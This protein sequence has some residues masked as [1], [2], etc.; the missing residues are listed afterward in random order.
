[1]DG[2]V[3]AILGLD[4]G[5]ECTGKVQPACTLRCSRVPE[6]LLDLIAGSTHPARNATDGSLRILTTW[7][8]VG[9]FQ[10]NNL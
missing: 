5:M 10:L 7:D 4:D 8:N 9:E 6:S 2:W 3:S 1:M